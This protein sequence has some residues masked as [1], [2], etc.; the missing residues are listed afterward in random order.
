MIMEKE[1]VEL[2]AEEK[3]NE[4]MHRKIAKTFFEYLPVLKV[5]K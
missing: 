2:V 4:R 5:I 1:H 3:Q